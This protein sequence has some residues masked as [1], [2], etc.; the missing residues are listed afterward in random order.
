MSLFDHPALP[1]LPTSPASL[2]PKPASKPTRRLTEAAK[3][4]M[5]ARGTM[6][7]HT[8]ATRHA[9]Y[10]KCGICKARTIIGLVNPHF[11]TYAVECDP[12]PLSAAGELGAIIAGR[13]LFDLSAHGGR[14]E[15]ATRGI[16][17]MRG[18][19]PGTPNNDV[20]VRHECGSPKL[21]SI[22]S[23]V[24]IKPKAQIAQLSDK[25]PF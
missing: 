23:S 14:W 17:T 20:L 24:Q 9:R 2:T 22:R 7:E 1:A 5:V 12:T 21:D 15:I 16:F 10:S 8:G 3:R 4:G 19:P 25:P 18:R 13:A 11:G 6:D